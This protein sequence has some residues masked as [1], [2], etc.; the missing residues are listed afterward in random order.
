MKRKFKVNVLSTFDTGL[1]QVDLLANPS[2]DPNA[3]KEITGKMVLV[4]HTP[5]QQAFFEAGKSYIVTFEEAPPEPKM[6]ITDG[7][8]KAN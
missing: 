7:K 1:V 2:P 5:E 6:E 3:P 8:T 4:G